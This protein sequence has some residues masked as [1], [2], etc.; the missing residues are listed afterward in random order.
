MSV[1]GQQIAHG[2]GVWRQSYGDAH[3]ISVLPLRPKA[4]EPFYRQ[5]F[6]A[7]SDMETRAYLAVRNCI[8]SRAGLTPSCYY[9]LNRVGLHGAAVIDAF[10][11]VAKSIGEIDPFETCP[12]CLTQ[13]H[14]ERCPECSWCP[15]PGNET[16]N[17]ERIAKRERDAVASQDGVSRMLETGVT[18]YVSS[19]QPHSREKRKREG[20]ET[21]RP[22][23]ERGHVVPREIQDRITAL[24]S[25][26]PASDEPLPKIDTARLVGAFRGTSTTMSDA[27]AALS[28]I[29][30]AASG[31][32]TFSIE[33]AEGHS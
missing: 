27:S 26:S 33:K 21:A 20:S 28:Q 32:P 19:F 3:S 22:L 12:V 15:L 2:D 4:S 10:S 11:D 13:M 6:T 1:V 8:E 30:Q 23:E 7:M 31:L 14:Q 9:L 18:R 16:D 17:L 5:P 24:F 25:P 29:A